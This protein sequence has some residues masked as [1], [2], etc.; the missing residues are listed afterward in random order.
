VLVRIVGAVMLIGGCVVALVAGGCG[1]SSGPGTATTPPALTEPLPATDVPGDGQP[2]QQWQMPDLAGTVLQ[3][4]QDQIQTLTGGAVYFTDSHDLSGEGRH[5]VMDDNWQ[6][7]TQNIAPG[8]A[9]TST[10]KIDFGVVKLDES[11][12]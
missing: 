11:C 5:Q 6:I 7:C 9:L 4:A 10:S 12:P 3:D 2:V 8:S 1:A